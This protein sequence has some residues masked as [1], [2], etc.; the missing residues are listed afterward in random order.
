M[1]EVFLQGLRDLGYVEERNLMIESRDAEGRL[2]R[3]PALAADLVGL[4]VD[5]IV[6][7]TI[8]AARAA[9]Q[10]P[11]SLPIVFAFVADPVGSGL[12]TSL[13]RP[14]GNVTGVPTGPRPRGR[15]LRTGCRGEQAVEPFRQTD[16]LSDGERAMLMGGACAKAYGWSP[17]RG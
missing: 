12:V 2:E 8:V 13:A 6:A 4:R 16:R 7:P 11:R 9:K 14:G 5:I 1:Q 17:K 15:Q 3:L 10:S